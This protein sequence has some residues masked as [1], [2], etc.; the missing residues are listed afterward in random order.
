[1]KNL[2][3]PVDLGHWGGGQHAT[4]CYGKHEIPNLSQYIG[5]PKCKWSY[6]LYILPEDAELTLSTC[7][8][9]FSHPSQLQQSSG[10]F[11]GSFNDA[12]SALGVSVSRERNHWRRV[13]LLQQG[14][15]K[16]SQLSLYVIA[17]VNAPMRDCTH[18][19][20]TGWT[21]FVDMLYD[22]SHLH[23][24]TGEIFAYIVACSR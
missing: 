2:W 17:Y 3:S 21:D 20:L 1:M 8:V 22:G 23:C 13:Q 10:W 4:T 12:V 14:A 18:I 7:T 6:G 5:H 24:P 11:I 19:Y 15:R 9:C 16:R